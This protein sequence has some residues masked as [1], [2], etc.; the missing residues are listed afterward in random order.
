MYR[1]H[2]NTRPPTRA[3]TVPT[4]TIVMVVVLESLD[5]EGVCEGGGVVWVS[6][7]ARKGLV[8]RPKV[9]S[10]V[11]GIAVAGAATRVVVGVDGFGDPSSEKKKAVEVKRDRPQARRT[12]EPPS[13]R[14]SPTFGVARR[15]FTLAHKFGYQNSVLK[16][17]PT[18]CPRPTSISGRPK[19]PRVYGRDWKIVATRTVDYSRRQIGCDQAGSAKFTGDSVDFLPLSLAI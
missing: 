10:V 15:L 16:G 12:V 11:V 13:N 14:Y 18:R 3:T 4:T 5:D 19:P 8:V 1:N 7:G 2:K 9:G 6:V 17:L